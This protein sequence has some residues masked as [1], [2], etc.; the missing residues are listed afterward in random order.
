MRHWLP[1]LIFA[2]CASAQ[3][4]KHSHDQH[5]HDKPPSHKPEPCGKGEFQGQFFADGKCA[6]QPCLPGQIRLSSGECMC[7]PGSDLI[8]GEC[9]YPPCPAGQ[10]RIN[11]HC[12]S[13]PPCLPGQVRD[14]SGACMCEPGSELVNGQCVYPPCPDGQFR[15]NTHCIPICPA[16]QILS[17]GQCVCAP[18]TEKAPGGNY[19]QRI[20][21]PCGTANITCP[22]GSGQIP[23][24]NKCVCPA[25]KE[26]SSKTGLCEEP[27]TD[28]H[29]GCPSGVQTG[30]CY[31][32]TFE[33]GHLFGYNSTSG[34]YTASPDHQFSKFQVCADQYC[35]PPLSTDIPTGKYFNLQEIFGLAP[36]T[37]NQ[38]SRIF[39]SHATQGAYM[40][41]TSD[42]SKSGGFVITKWPGGK[43]CLGSYQSGA[44]VGLIAQA[45]SVGATTLP[46]DE[47]SCLL[48][49]LTEVPCD[50]R[51]PDAN[52]IAGNKTETP[53]SPAG[54]KGSLNASMPSC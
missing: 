36:P 52:C 1:A 41:R 39:V 10:I 31:T 37:S 28:P 15:I 18:G 49:T 24:G 23:E 29:P 9:V 22:T 43:H 46:S 48:I 5:G 38:R 2:L 25:G 14:S 44:G 34:F 4:H 12:V 26:L 13:V 19:C 17:G 16:G 3:D 47:Q 45:G 30:K 7:E 11:T 27:K 50:I 8:N 20:C 40:T 32:F 42:F 35:S 6:K 54:G 53:A 51:A 33:N 21:Q